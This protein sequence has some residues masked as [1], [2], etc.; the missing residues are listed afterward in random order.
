MLYYKKGNILLTCIT[1]CIIVYRSTYSACI[2]FEKRDRSLYH[3]PIAPSVPTGWNASK[4]LRLPSQVKYL[5]RYVSQ[6]SQLS[7]LQSPPEKLQ[8][9]SYV[10]QQI[11]T[12]M[13]QLSQVSQTM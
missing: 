13:S 12:H 2:P 1:I 11:S 6:G 5:Q 9:T 4:K 8:I 7:L 10:V 3:V